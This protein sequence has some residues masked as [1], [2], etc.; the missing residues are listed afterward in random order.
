M[1]KKGTIIKFSHQQSVEQLF[2]INIDAET[3]SLS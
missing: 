3:S 2:H 1:M